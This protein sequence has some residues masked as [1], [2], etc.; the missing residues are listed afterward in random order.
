MQFIIFLGQIFSLFPVQ[1]FR[2]QNVEDLKFSWISARVFYNFFTSLGLLYLT[3]TITYSTSGGGINIFELTIIIFHVTTLINSLLFLQLAI[4]WPNLMKKWTETETSMKSY[5]WPKGLDF[6]LKT[7]CA[8]IFISA[9]VEF[10]L[11]KVSKLLLSYTCKKET[12]GIFEFYVVRTLFLEVFNII[13]YSTWQGIILQIINV[14]ATF[15]WT[16]IDVFIM[17]L[18]TALAFRFKQITHRLKIFVNGKVDNVTVWRSIREDYN[19]LCILTREVNEAISNMI[20]LSF[21]TNL[22]FIIIQMFHSLRYMNN[23]IEKVYFFFSFG[24]LIMRTLC[25][26]LYG[27]SVNDESNEP[28]DILFNLPSKRYNI[29]IARFLQ[30]LQYDKVSLSGRGFFHITRRILLSMAGAIVTYELVVIQTCGDILEQSIKEKN[31]TTIC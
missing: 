21:S 2:S 18:S 15:A 12:E 31:T 20:L 10:S 8:V 17:V 14:N 1:G 6:H 13:P 30:Q 25:V 23:N 29:E 16:Y 22:T 19:K 24:F 11:T 9:L 4:K 5:G 3:L 28:T 26:S 7:L 27:A